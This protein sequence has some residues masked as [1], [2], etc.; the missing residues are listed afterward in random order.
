MQQVSWQSLLQLVLRYFGEQK[1]NSGIIIID[2]DGKDIGIK[3]R[4]AKVYA[5]GDEQKDVSSGDWIL[6]EHGRWTR[7]IT[8][9]DAD[10]NEI[11]IRRVDN[12]AILLQAD[13]P[14]KDVYI[15]K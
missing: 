8:L 3:P 6:I 15:P 1:T 11:I 14:P 2:D 13:E 9:E 10:G 4:W 7:G 12:D 5:V